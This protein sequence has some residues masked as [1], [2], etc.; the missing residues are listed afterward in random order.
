MKLSF[1]ISNDVLSR[2]TE[3]IFELLLSSEFNR[4]LVTKVEYCIKNETNSFFKMS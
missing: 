3:N 2:S 4:V 1:I